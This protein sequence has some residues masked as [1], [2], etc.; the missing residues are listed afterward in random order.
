MLM[1]TE[2][3]PDRSLEDV[4][5][6]ILTRHGVSETKAEDIVKLTF[7]TPALTRN[8]PD[9]DDVPDIVTDS[10]AKAD[11]EAHLDEDADPEQVREQLD[12]ALEDALQGTLSGPATVSDATLAQ[13]FGVVTAD[14]DDGD[15]SPRMGVGQPDTG[16]AWKGAETNWGAKSE[17]SDEDIDTLADALEQ[18]QKEHGLEIEDLYAALERLEERTH[19]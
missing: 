8:I 16:V 3:D 13:P 12:D 2:N 17:L 5:R 7:G 9:I 1:T 11:L 4:W 10:R 19:E 18:I 6:D 15:A 14:A